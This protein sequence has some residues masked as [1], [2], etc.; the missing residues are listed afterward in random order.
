MCR[1]LNNT[2]ILYI[3]INTDVC[4]KVNKIIKFVFNYYPLKIIY[5]NKL[6]GE[7]LIVDI[8]FSHQELSLQL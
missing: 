6:S 4:F 8:F 7:T 2:R 3:I 1:S 5:I